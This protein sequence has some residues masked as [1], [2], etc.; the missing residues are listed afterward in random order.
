[1]LEGQGSQRNVET[2]TIGVGNG[3]TDVHPHVVSGFVGNDAIDAERPLTDLCHR[4]LSSRVSPDEAAGRSK[5]E[6]RARPRFPSI[7]DVGKRVACTVPPSC[8]PAGQK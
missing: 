5:S 1:C 8:S 6:A 2:F 7:W 3:A 4:K